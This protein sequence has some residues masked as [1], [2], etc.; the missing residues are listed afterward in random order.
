MIR[1][2]GAKAPQT[3]A[4]RKKS[5]RARNRAAGLVMVKFPELWVEPAVAAKI[6]TACAVIIANAKNGEL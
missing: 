2:K 1:G 5:Q 4:Q 3:S 6:Q